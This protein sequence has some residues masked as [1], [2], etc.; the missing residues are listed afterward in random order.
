M[1]PVRGCSVL[2]GWK[3]GFVSAKASWCP[4]VGGPITVG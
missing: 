2:K 4:I 1:Q 3:E